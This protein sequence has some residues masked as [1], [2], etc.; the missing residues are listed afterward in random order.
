MSAAATAGNAVRRPQR[1]KRPA[2]TARMNADTSAVSVGPSGSLES[3]SASSIIA[4]STQSEPFWLRLDFR[5]P[6]LRVT[7]PLQSFNDSKNNFYRGFFTKGCRLK[8]FNRVESTPGGRPSS[9]SRA[10]TCSPS[11]RGTGTRLRFPAPAVPA[12]FFLGI[13]EEF[14]RWHLMCEGGTGRVAQRPR[15]TSSHYFAY[16]SG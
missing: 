2:F 12:G 5:H 16:A 11:G 10:L 8:L 15:L 13:V 3:R 4:T 7:V 1:S 6:E 14:V 9:C